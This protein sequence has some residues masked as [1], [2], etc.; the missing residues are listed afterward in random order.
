MKVLVTGANGFIGSHVCR[1]LAA[2]G[3][4]I[5]ALVRPGA[6]T[7]RLRV[8]DSDLEWSH[9]DLLGASDEQLEAL[10]QGV[11]ACIH[12]AWAVTP[13][14]YLLSATNPQYRDASLRLFAALVKRGCAHIT[15]VGTC[16]EYAPSDRPLAETSLLD[17]TTPYAREKLTAATRGAELMNGSA[18]SFAWARLF[19]LYGPG[20]SPRRLVS[21]VAIG[22]LEGNRVAVTTGRQ[23]RDFLHVADVARALT[24]VTLSAVPGPMNI[25]SGEPVRVI[26]VVNTIASIAGRPDL[27][28]VGARPDNVVD[29]PY[30]CADNTRL[31]TET[32]WRR[33]YS[34]AE[35]IAD[36]MAW[37]REALRIPPR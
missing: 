21:D 27:L 4:A 35:G 20:E 17:P 7:R 12:L 37:W 9:C 26:D 11:E 34:L 15:G 19:Y 28:D 2:R 23:Q 14:Q 32:E 16:F 3:I 36:T 13:G 6:D 29:P 25:G 5:R 33:R 10:A 22:L 18:T 1:E 31:R 8:L 24:V 30:V